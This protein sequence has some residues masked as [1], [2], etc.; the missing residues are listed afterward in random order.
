MSLLRLLALSYLA[1]ASVFAMAA[2]LAVHPQL[3]GNLMRGTRALVQ[4]ADDDLVQP[5]LVTPQPEAIARVELAPAAPAQHRQAAR[6]SAQS[7]IAV[8][9][10][11]TVE[12]PDMRMAAQPDWNGV[13][14]LPD[15]P[16]APAPD[17]KVAS[18]EPHTVSPDFRIPDPPAADAP[19][20]GRSQLVA[21]RLQAG[22]TPEM[23]NNFDLF[24]YVSK[25]DSGPLS[26]RMYV[27]ARQR[28]GALKLLYDWAASTGREQHETSPRGERTLTTTPAGYYELDPD[29]MYR[30][31]RSYNWDQ[32]MPDAM[33]FNWEREGLETGLAIHAATGRDI[34]KLGVRASAGCVHL[35]PEHAAMLFDLIRKGYRGPVPRFAYDAASETMS[36]QG[37][38]M[39]DRAGRLK[40]ANGYRVLIRIENYGGNDMVAALF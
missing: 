17:K 29:R 23:R 8:P 12:A 19:I 13:A 36:N 1:A 28:S 10:P 15:L 22:L 16:E 2:T 30:N 24:L 35:A 4:M 6:S 18:N 14:I 7:A 34:E 3:I 31:Y 9:L 5:F 38:F 25:A 33:F 37:K 21:A 20:Q 26:Q 27:F 39:H 32:D 40:M 11:R